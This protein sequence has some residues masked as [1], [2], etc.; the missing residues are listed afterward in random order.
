MTTI[1][2]RMPGNVIE[3]LGETAPASGFSGFNP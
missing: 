2:I 1:G 3:D